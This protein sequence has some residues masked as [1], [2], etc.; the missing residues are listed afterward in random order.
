MDVGAG[1]RRLHSSRA[2]PINEVISSALH[3]HKYRSQA[4]LSNAALFANLHCNNFLYYTS[5]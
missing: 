4:G 2:L 1:R 3:P 5:W